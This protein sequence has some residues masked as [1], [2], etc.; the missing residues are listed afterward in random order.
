MG[1]NHLPFMEMIMKLRECRLDLNAL[2]DR[3]GELGLAQDSLAFC[4]DVFQ[5]YQSGTEPANEH[6]DIDKARN[7][8]LDAVFR[9]LKV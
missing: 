7:Q 1:I 9:I 8:L 2:S 4:A 3:I 5:R 6:M